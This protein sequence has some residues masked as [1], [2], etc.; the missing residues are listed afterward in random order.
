MHDPDAALLSLDRSNFGCTT[1]EWSIRWW[2]WLL[3]IPEA[4]NP[5]FDSTGKNCGLFQEYQDVFF[6]C[7]TLGN[8]ERPIF[9][10]ASIPKDKTLFMP[11][12]NWVSLSGVD[13]K[14]DEEL[15]LAAKKKIDSVTNLK[16]QLNGI[17]VG[18]LSGCRIRSKAFDITLPE[19]NILNATHGPTRCV[20]DGYWV[21]LKP[22]KEN[23]TISTF[24]CC[25]SGI[26][27]IAISYELSLL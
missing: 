18:G 27:R 2:R 11:V 7:Q 14:T 5:A 3:S 24:G 16:F 26:N 13:G 6:L 10:K 12:I 25:S 1:D 23:A 4:N 20:S 21:F 8:S 22:I 17:E 15:S 9:R 19:K